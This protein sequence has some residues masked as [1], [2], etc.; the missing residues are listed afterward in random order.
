MC[1]VQRRAAELWGPGMTQAVGTAFA[2]PYSGRGLLRVTEVYV[3]EQLEV[4]E[5]DLGIKERVFSR[6]ANQSDLCFIKF[7]LAARGRAR[8]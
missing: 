7:T 5:L 4:S 3:G 6:G 2:K 1:R 8:R